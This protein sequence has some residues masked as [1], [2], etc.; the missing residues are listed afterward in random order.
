V[1]VREG[2][3]TPSS[4]ASGAGRRDTS[5]GLTLGLAATLARWCPDEGI[6]R[7]SYCAI[8]VSEVMSKRGRRVLLAVAVVGALLT[9]GS[10]VADATAADVLSWASASVALSIFGAVLYWRFRRP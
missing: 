9:I 1:R 8:R 2:R 10:Q 5:R 3:R 4:R 7:I 6:V